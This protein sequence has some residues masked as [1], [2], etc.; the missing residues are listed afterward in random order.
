MVDDSRQ[1]GALASI[2]ESGQLSR[3]A[4]PL[5]IKFDDLVRA[6]ALALAWERD[7]PPFDRDFRGMLLAAKVYEHLAAA[8]AVNSQTGIREEAA[9]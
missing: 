5:N 8:A 2:G 3:L 4:L 9:G 7:E 6:G 1:A